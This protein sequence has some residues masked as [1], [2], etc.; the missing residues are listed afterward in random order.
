MFSIVFIFVLY[1]TA[2]PLSKVWDDLSTELKGEDAFGSDNVTV[3][4]IED[5]DAFLTPAYDQLI[6]ISFAGLILV[7]IISAIF[8]KDHPV[9]IIFLVIGFVVIVIIASQL[10]NVA[11]TAVRDDILEDKIDDFTLAPLIFGSAFPVIV[12][13]VGMVVILIVISRSGRAVA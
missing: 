13:I 10:V 11:D 9:F 6:F 5:V 3:E 8:F 2:I 12:F 1:L 4:K 7:F